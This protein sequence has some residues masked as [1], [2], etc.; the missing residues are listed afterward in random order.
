MDVPHTVTDDDKKNEN[1]E[2]ALRK[3]QLAEDAETRR[4]RGPQRPADEVPAP[5]AAPATPAPAPVAAKPARP[6]R[7]AVAA[8]AR[9]VTRDMGSARPTS[10]PAAS[11]PKEP[12][13]TP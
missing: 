7:P 13:K 4:V 3:R 6:V 11:E 1:A 9:P 12:S 8:P 10:E 5:A 2:E